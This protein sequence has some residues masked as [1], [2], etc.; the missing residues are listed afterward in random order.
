MHKITK[1][2]GWVLRYFAPR[3]LGYLKIGRKRRGRDP[4]LVPCSKREAHVYPS[5][6]AARAHLER[7]GWFNPEQWRACRRGKIDR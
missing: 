1:P 2:T 6:A 5:A 3:A 7:D 4:L